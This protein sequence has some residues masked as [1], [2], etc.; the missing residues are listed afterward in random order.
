MVLKCI[1]ENNFLDMISRLEV[2]TR[3]IDKKFLSQKQVDTVKSWERALKSM[4]DYFTRTKQYKK[5][6]EYG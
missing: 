5:I 6:I 1:K 2:H 4:E 3:T